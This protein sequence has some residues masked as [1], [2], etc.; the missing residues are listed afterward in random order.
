MKNNKYV[1]LLAAT[2]GLGFSACS[3]DDLIVEEIGG[4]QGATGNGAAGGE[5]V[6]FTSRIAGDL[7]ILEEE[8]GN[9]SSDTRSVIEGGQFTAWTVGDAVTVSDGMLA[10]TYQVS[11]TS[12]TSCS[13][14]VKE[15]GN[16]F[17]TATTTTDQ[18]FYAF[19]PEAAVSGAGGRGGWSGSTVKAMIFA[20]QNYAENVDDGLFGSYMASGATTM[21]ESGSVNFT[22]NLVASVIDVNLSTLGVTPASVSIKSNKGEILAGLL[23]YN[24]ATQ[25]AEVSTNDKTK[26]ADNTQSDVVTVNKIAE[27]ATLVRFYVLPVQL[28]G[29]V[30]IT[31]KDT[32]GNYYTKSST[33]PV[34]NEATEGLT[35]LTGVTA[36]VCKPYYKKYN[37]GAVSS[38]A[39][40]QNNWM[41]TIPSNVRYCQL[42]IPGAHDAATS[43]VSGIGANSAKTQSKDIATLLAG[44]VRGFDLRPRHTA[45]SASEI[46]L[47]YLEIYHGSK[48]TGVLFKDAMS[49]L[50]EFVTNNPTECVYVRIKKED[51]GET[52]QPE[53]WCTSIRECLKGY[54][55]SDIVLGKLPSG[56]T[57]GE[58]RGKLVVTS[59][60]PYG[61][62]R[63]Y[64]PVYG[65]FLSWNDNTEGA[66]FTIYHDG[67]TSNKLGN[68]YVQ[69][70]YSGDTSNKSTYVDNGFAKAAEQTDVWCFNYLNMSATLIVP[71][72]YAGTINPD[73]LSKL[74]AL[75][76]RVG[77]VFYD[78][79]L[80]NSYSGLD[81]NNAIIAQNFKYIYKGRSRVVAETSGGTSTGTTVSGDEYADDSEV[82]V[83]GQR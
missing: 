74:N 29:G 76:G 62:G 38:S 54:Y 31:V 68:A 83:K 59:D 52:D 80:D 81:L 78:F 41:A 22:F 5:G 47:D 44:G 34:G 15:G 17:L 6:S 51:T 65:A 64:S 58:C 25:T 23:K 21:S 14:A 1:Y 8:G 70:Y 67:G 3:S 28:A 2:L 36:T 75:N 19:Y 26:Y 39:T 37:F 71:A 48:G 30:T 57:L 12:G 13:F 42:S 53:T 18:P 32:E 7:D 33:T 43:G 9:A 63:T 69:D 16:E 49:L 50:A 77:F 72:S 35:S 79:C 45:S 73:V 55:D 60:N 82:Y 61:P 56:M 46:E 20:E 27:G 24:C 4:A 40:R 10:Y 66:L 11:A